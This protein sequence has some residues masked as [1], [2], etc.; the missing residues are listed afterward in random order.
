VRGLL[1]RSALA[2]DRR[3]GHRL[4]EAGGEH[5]VAGDV[6]GLLTDLHHAAHHDVVDLA[7]SMPVRSTSARNVSAARSTGCQSF[8]L[9]VAPAERRADGVDDHCGGHG[10]LQTWRSARAHMHEPVGEAWSAL[11]GDLKPEPLRIVTR[12]Q[13]PV[14]SF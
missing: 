8:N 10:V 4:G 13:P 7:G 11:A 14:R 1:A 12:P 9:P 5:G 3:A 6:R 2:V